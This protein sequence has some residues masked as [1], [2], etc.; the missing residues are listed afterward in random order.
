MHDPL[1]ALSHGA[2]LVI[3]VAILISVTVS[4]L[5]TVVVP[6]PLRSNFSDIVSALV[7]GVTRLIARTRRDYADKDAILTWGGPV[8]ILA[9]LVSWLAGYLV[10]YT[11]L[12]FGASA[13]RTIGEAFRQAG[14]NLFTLG[15]GG[16][17]DGTITII[18]FMAAATGPI[19]IAMLIAFLPSVY[20]SYLDRERTMAELSSVAG[21]PI[22]APEWLARAA[23]AGSIDN[24]VANMGT[25]ADWATNLRLT[26]STYPVLQHIRPPR[27]TR[28]PIVTLLAMLDAANLLASL[29]T[30]VP[31]R[32]LFIMIVNGSQALGILYDLF[33]APR[34][35]RSRI[36]IVGRLLQGDP[37]GNA[38]VYVV[39]AWQRNLAAIHVAS[40]RD[41]ARGM[42]PWRSGALHTGEERASQLTRA[43]F[44]QAVDMLRE[45]GLPIDRDPDASWTM[46][47][48]IRAGYEFPAYEI[49]RTLTAVPAPWSGPRDGNIATIWPTSVLEVLRRGDLVDDRPDSPPAA[50]S[51]EG[52]E[53]GFG[54]SA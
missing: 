21:E 37:T 27:Y 41:A 23:V 3:G 5:R 2:A 11:F 12:E 54:A 8:L 31:H 47:Q 33:Y 48:Q 36:P 9:L 15:M 52:P 7:I 28:H 26:H 38:E 29:C 43:E 45:A 39:P 46:F 16:T 50:P 22:W 6:R 30:K 42:A 32:P 44:D 20:S 53:P 17:H 51:G 35:W 4:L 1:D 40:A 19:V 10:A 24:V 14:S 18:D 13:D 25:Y 34:S 49:A